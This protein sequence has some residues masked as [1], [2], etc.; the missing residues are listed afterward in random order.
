MISCRWFVWLRVFIVMFIPSLWWWN[1]RTVISSYSSRDPRWAEMIEAI[2]SLCRLVISKS[3]LLIGWWR[4]SKSGILFIF[5]KLILKLAIIFELSFHTL[6]IIIN[7]ISSN[8]GS[9][10]SRPAITA[11]RSDQTFVENLFSHC[12]HQ[13]A[14]KWTIQKRNEIQC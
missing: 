6:L 11:I 2:I 5:K 7:A 3:R 13:H 9:P 4:F 8:Q 12:L 1:S 10:G 14:K